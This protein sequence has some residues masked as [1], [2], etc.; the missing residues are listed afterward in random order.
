MCSS[1]A[2]GRLKRRFMFHCLKEAGYAI[3][4]RCGETILNEKDLTLDH[5]VD[6]LDSS[7]PSINFWDLGNLAFSHRAC[8]KRREKRDSNGQYIN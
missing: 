3:C 4:Y 7:I 2:R 1:T 5:K 6:W 8:N